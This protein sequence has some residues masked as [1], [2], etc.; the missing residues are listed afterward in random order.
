[1]AT[2]AYTIE[3]PADGDIYPEG[4]RVVKWA[5]LASGDVGQPYRAPHY[6]DKT[7]QVSGT[8]GTG[9]NCRIE[10]SLAY[11]GAPV[12]ATLTDPQGNNLDFTAAKLESV[13]ENVVD[14][15][16]NITAGD[17]T[18]SITVRLLVSTVARR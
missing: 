16:P 6:S 3:L 17:G 7:V 13:A 8:F 9:G 11:S 2:V 4:V 1:M 12:W 18:T 5:N 10:G 15:R 14:I